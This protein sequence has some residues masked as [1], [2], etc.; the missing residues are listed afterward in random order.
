LSV[1]PIRF[2]FPDALGGCVWQSGCAK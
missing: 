1:Q 2:K